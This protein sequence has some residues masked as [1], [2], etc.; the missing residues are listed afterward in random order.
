MYL[1]MSNGRKINLIENL[2][3][4]ADLYSLLILYLV[5]CKLQY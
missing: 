4:C 5:L 2:I 1:Q 3:L